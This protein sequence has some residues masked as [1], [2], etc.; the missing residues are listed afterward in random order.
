VQLNTNLNL[1]VWWG[2]YLDNEN[3]FKKQGDENQEGDNWFC[4]D[5]IL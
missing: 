4:Q 3:G 1:T 2:F 5:L